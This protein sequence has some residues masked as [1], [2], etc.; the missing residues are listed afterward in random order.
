MKRFFIC[1]IL[2]V[3]LAGCSGIP[4]RSL[5]RLAQ[6]SESLLKANP[7][8]FMVALQVDAR[9]VPPPGAVPRLIVKLTPRD[10]SAFDPFDK[11][12]PLQLA[13][14]SS[15]T[16]GLKAP[17]TGRRWLLYSMPPATQAELRRVQALVRQAQTAPEKKRGGS[18]SVGVEQD[19]LAVT[20]PVLSRTRWDTWLQVR[21]SE[22]FFEVWSGTPEQLRRA[23]QARQHTR[24]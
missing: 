1:L 3:A 6:L 23:A 11:K 22:G 9:L 18:L 17:P 16:L 13:V 12:L 24:P 15:A 7:A 21:Q 10:P 20:D 14:V 5:P 8:E 19:S 2:S 4:L